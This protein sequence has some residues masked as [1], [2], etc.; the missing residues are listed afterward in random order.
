MAPPIF[1]KTPLHLPRILPVLDFDYDDVAEAAALDSIARCGMIDLHPDCWGAHDGANVYTDDPSVLS[2]G[3][4]KKYKQEAK[5]RRALTEKRD[6]DAWVERELRE[7]KRRQRALHLARG[8]RRKFEDFLASPSPWTRE[9]LSSALEPIVLRFPHCDAVLRRA[10]IVEFMADGW[11]DAERRNMP[12]L[13]WL[14][15]RSRFMAGFT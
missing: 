7:K 9:R 15:K 1:A 10:A 2:E 3:E 14:W 8:F 5:E 11:K 6:L 13:K 12:A 4:K